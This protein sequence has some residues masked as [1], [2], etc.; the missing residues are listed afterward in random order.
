MLK[1]CHGFQAST[2]IRAVESIDN[3]VEQS[4]NEHLTF[5]ESWS[6]GEGSINSSVQTKLEHMLFN[7]SDIVKFVKNI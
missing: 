1:M 6:Q 3:R 5:R 4:V 2:S 7:T